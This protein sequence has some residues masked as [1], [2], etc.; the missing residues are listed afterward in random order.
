[1]KEAEATTREFFFS[2]KNEDENGLVRLYRDFSKF[3]QYYKSD[4]GKIVSTTQ[5]NGII[6]VTVDNR[7]INKFGKLSQE[8]IFL[9]YKVDSL[10]RAILYD[11]KGLSDF[12]DNDD[13][14]FGSKTG[15]IDNRTDTTDQ[16]IIKKLKKARQVLLDRAVSLYLELKTNI[17]VINWDWES[18]FGGSASGRGIV[19]NGSTYNIPK[20]KYKVTYKDQVGKPTQI[21]PLSPN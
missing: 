18:G 16:Q 5:S 12:D 6:T 17:R 1:M 7:F 21:D 14:I 15:C 19:R 3:E 2:L 9:Y 8:R 10:G 20:L 13:F 4:S 11:S